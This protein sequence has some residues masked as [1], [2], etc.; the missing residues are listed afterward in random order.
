MKPTDSEFQVCHDDSTP[1]VRAQ[2]IHELHSLQKKKSTPSTPLSATQGPFATV[3]DEERQ[4]QQLQSIRY[5]LIIML[6]G[7]CLRNSHDG[8]AWA[9]TF[10]FYFCRFLLIVRRWRRWRGSQG[11]RWWKETQPLRQRRGHMFITIRNHITLLQRRLMSVT[12][13]SNSPTSSTISPPLVILYYI[14][15]KSYHQ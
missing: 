14:F 5:A 11:L 2:T 3:S 10:S 1:P 15:S 7:Y 13:R 6:L 8:S 4:K 9:V 12:V